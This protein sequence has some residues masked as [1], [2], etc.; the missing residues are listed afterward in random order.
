MCHV[1]YREDSSIE[2]VRLERFYCTFETVENL[3]VNLNYGFVFFYPRISL[4]E[5]H[6]LLEKFRRIDHHGKG[7]ITVSEFAKYLQ[8][9]ES[10]SLKEVFALYD[11]VSNQGNHH[12]NVS[13]LELRS[14]FD[15]T[16]TRTNLCLWVAR[17]SGK[18]VRL[19]INAFLFP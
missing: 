3:M 19:V 7:H 12:S 6:T 11:R 15:D 9:P 4:D 5:M 16:I 13:W 8:I 1:W 10:H 17:L 18:S 2:G 14:L